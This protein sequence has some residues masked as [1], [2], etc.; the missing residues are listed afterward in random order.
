MYVSV[1]EIPRTR[2][3]LCLRDSGNMCVSVS[4]KFLE[5]LCL[6]IYEIPGTCVPLRLLYFLFGSFSS[7]F[8]CPIPFF[9]V[10]DA[11]FFSNERESMQILIGKE[12]KRS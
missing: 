9:P 1:Y 11:Y 7:V 2:V 4:M 10:L 3:S 12:L 6:C 8:F 5:Y